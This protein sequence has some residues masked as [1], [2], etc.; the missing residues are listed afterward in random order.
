MFVC[1]QSRDVALCTKC[2]RRDEKNPS[3]RDQFVT[4]AT[5]EGGRRKLLRTNRSPSKNKPRTPAQELADD[6][7]RFD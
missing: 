2:Y 6:V 5:G 1:D 7:F 4:R 3:A